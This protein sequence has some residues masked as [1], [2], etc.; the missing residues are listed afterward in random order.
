VKF[1]CGDDSENS[2]LNSLSFEDIDNSLK[3][4][5]ADLFF[6]APDIDKTKASPPRKVPATSLKKA[7]QRWSSAV[8]RGATYRQDLLASSFHSQLKYSSTAIRPILNK[9]DLP[10][11]PDLET[12]R[13]IPS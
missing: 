11:P 13:L 2:G 12:L 10:F 7:I 6:D 8:S 9:W 3:T 5:K 4:L 1:V